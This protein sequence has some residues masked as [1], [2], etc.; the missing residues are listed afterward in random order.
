MDHS[1]STPE[2]A[3]SGPAIPRIGPEYP[4][5]LRAFARAEAYWSPEVSP[6]L[7]KIDFI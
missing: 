6:Q 7:K 3:L 2:A 4:S 5:S 1:I